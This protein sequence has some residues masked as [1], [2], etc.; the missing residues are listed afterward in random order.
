MPRQTD[1]DAPGAP[2]DDDDRLIRDP[3]EALGFCSD[4][5]RE[6]RIGGIGVTERKLSAQ[7]DDSPT[8]A[9]AGVVAL[10]V[11]D[12]EYIVQWV[13]APESF[14]EGSYQLY[15]TSDA[16]EDPDELV[17]EF[18]SLADA[19]S[20]AVKHVVKDRLWELTH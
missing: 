6:T 12:D 8:G 10:S 2:D 16:Q 14:A 4:L 17:A 1:S 7:T 15:M 13:E 19:F 20:H 11:G 5:L 18:V 9:V 3:R